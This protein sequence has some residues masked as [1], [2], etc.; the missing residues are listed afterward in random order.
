M[1]TKLLQSI[2]GYT[3]LWTEQSTIM[4]LLCDTLVKQWN[5]KTTYPILIAKY[6]YIVWLLDNSVG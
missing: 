3:T 1:I 5:V 4:Q 2:C 6:R